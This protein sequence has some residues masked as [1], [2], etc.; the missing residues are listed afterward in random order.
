MTRPTGAGHDPAADEPPTIAR[1]DLV[2]AVRAGLVTPVEA[3]GPAY[4]ADAHL[5]GAVNL[6]PGRVSSQ[7]ASLLPDRDADIVVYGSATSPSSLS[8]ARL[9][10]SLGYTRI[11]H[12]PA[13]KEDWV[14]HGMPVERTP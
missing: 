5:P 9:L 11:R 10:R 4:Y 12:Y 2:D 6:T 7:A 14:E 3:L 1:R 8:V 13:G